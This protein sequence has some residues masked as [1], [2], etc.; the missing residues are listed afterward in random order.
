MPASPCRRLWV[1]A[2]TATLAEI[3]STALMLVEPEEIA[4]LMAG[5]EGIGGVYRDRNG[6]VVS[7]REQGPDSGSLLAKTSP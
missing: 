4:E 2:A 5:E 3:W 1:R 6:G 7:L